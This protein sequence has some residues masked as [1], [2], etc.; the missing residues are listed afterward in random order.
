MR[1]LILLLV[2]FWMA[3]ILVRGFFGALRGLVNPPH[4]T[5]GAKTKA[6]Q[7]NLASRR[8]VRDP[9][10]G[11]HVAEGLALPLR[12]GGEIVH[13]CSA[14]CRDKYVAGQGKMAANG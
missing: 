6:R 13:F 8:L 14:A 5:P 7:E 12:V 9:V 11:V 2:L 4:Q 1:F 3:V 10:C